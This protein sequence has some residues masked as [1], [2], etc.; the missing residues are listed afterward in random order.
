MDSSQAPRPGNPAPR[1]QEHSIKAR[2]QSMFG[3]DELADRPAAGPT[4]PFAEYVRTTAAAPLS[5]LAKAGLWG[6]GVVV[7]LLLL[8]ALLKG[9]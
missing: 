7:V 1:E 9:R 6:A 8:A 3:E 4:K 5:T 2:K